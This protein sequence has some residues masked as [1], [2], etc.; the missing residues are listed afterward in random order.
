MLELNSKQTTCERQFEERLRQERR[1][2]DWHKTEIC[3]DKRRQRERFTEWPE[4]GQSANRLR[5]WA[6]YSIGRCHWPRVEDGLRRGRC[7]QGRGGGGHLMMHIVIFMRQEQFSS[8]LFNELK[9][10]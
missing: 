2:F 3:S 1:R 7:Q 8:L 4:I 9:D 10:L 5:R 6:H